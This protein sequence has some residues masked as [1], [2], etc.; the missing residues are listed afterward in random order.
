VQSI[1]AGA[2]DYIPKEFLGRAQVLSA[3]QRALL[4]CK[5][6]LGGESAD[7]P[8]VLRLFGY[9]IRRCLAN[10]GNDSVHVAYSAERGC[11]VVL[12]VLHRGRGALSRDRNCERFVSE[13]KLLYD[14]HDPAVAEIYDF[15]V[16]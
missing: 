4:H 3:V 13:F 14:I 2:F 6:V 8:G 1:K 5:A 9:D 16:T 10:H 15:R 11:E 12:K 7:V